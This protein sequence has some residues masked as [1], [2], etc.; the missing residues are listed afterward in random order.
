ML[1]IFKT[2][3]YECGCI[4]PIIDLEA[5]RTCLSI[6]DV[7]VN[8]WRHVVSK[9]CFHVNITHSPQI[10]N[11][12]SNISISKQTWC[13]DGSTGWAQNS[14][15]AQKIGKSK[16]QE[17]HRFLHFF[18]AQKASFSFTTEEQRGQKSEGLWGVVEQP[19]QNPKNTTLFEHEAFCGSSCP[20]TAAKRA[21]G[22][23]G[24]GNSSFCICQTPT[25]GR[26]SV[27]MVLK[28]HVKTY[29]KI[30]LMVFMFVIVLLPLNPTYFPWWCCWLMQ[31]SLTHTTMS[32]THTQCGISWTCG[33]GNNWY[34]LLN[35]PYPL[36]NGMWSMK[37]FLKQELVPW[38]WISSLMI[39]P[40]GW[41]TFFDSL[42]ITLNSF[43]AD[44]ADQFLAGVACIDPKGD[45][46]LFL[47]KRVGR[48]GWSVACFLRLC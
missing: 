20:D 16:V 15:N 3:S 34:L 44:Q 39:R 28:I 5:W 18:R 6:T 45:Q 32:I 33:H 9:V 11:M 14:E 46:P 41:S 10:N 4:I 38:L 8:W 48:S 40:P 2:I 43:N 19:W 17:N 22:L 12:D 25:P 21:C 24:L 37:V 13:F 36:F 27:T 7:D 29:I 31:W 30:T 1:T 23:S 42:L 47:I 26:I 35:P